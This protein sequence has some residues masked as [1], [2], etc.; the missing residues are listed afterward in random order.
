MPTT[1]LPPITS[2]DAPAFNRIGHDVSSHNF[3]DNI[4]SESL[5]RD[6]QNVADV[7]RTAELGGPHLRTSTATAEFAPLC[8]SNL[9]FLRSFDSTCLETFNG[10][11]IHGL[12]PKPFWKR[13]ESSMMLPRR[14]LA[15]NLLHAYFTFAHDFLPV[16]YRPSFEWRYERLW[17]P[18]PPDICEGPHP[19]TEDG[20]FLAILNVCF[21]LGSLF[22]DLIADEDRES[23]GEAFYQ[24]SRAL[25][26]FDIC[27]Y[28]SLTAVRLQLLTGLYLQTT[29]HVSRCWNV[30][31]VA[32]RLAQDLELHMDPSVYGEYDISN[33][34]VK[35]RVWY[36]CV[37]MDR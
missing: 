2:N 11:K 26:N 3:E 31:G 9:G 22:S 16:F 36:S 19:N 13:S 34:E 28:S 8:S 21:A 17:M 14:P 4:L 25:T 35:R 7:D 6:R 33:V 27:D 5:A 23:T 15:D 32:I 10:E 29:P 20:L 1:E 12:Y 18:D 24:R 37:V 30:V